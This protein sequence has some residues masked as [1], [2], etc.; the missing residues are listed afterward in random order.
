MFA[1]YAS[2]LLLH[3][4]DVEGACNML[5]HTLCLCLRVTFDWAMA[6]TCARRLVK[7]ALT[8]GSGARVVEALR[9][10]ANGV[11]D[12]VLAQ[13]STAAA[14]RYTSS[15]S[16][17]SSSAS[18]SSS[19]AA[20]ASSSPSSLLG[21]EVYLRTLMGFCY[22]AMGHTHMGMMSFEHAAQLSAQEDCG[23]GAA[24]ASPIFGC[25]GNLLYY[26]Q[27]YEGSILCHA[28]ALQITDEPQPQLSGGGGTTMSAR[29]GLV[30]M[31]AVCLGNLARSLRAN[32]DEN[33]AD[34]YGVG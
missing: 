19:S 6:A 24:V 29:R 11:A 21:I 25:L 7:C 10:T 8:H 27:K 28:R 16:S 26:Q 20:A 15:A 3:V 22:M 30:G 23:G 34:R 17:S 2:G 9:Q 31:K 1:F 32:G 14:S 33:M 4:G 13:N 5:E 18:S 12:Y